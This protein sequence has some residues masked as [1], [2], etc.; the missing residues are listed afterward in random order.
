M[1]KPLELSMGTQTDSHFEVPT[2]RN[3]Y[4]YIYNSLGFISPNKSVRL[5]ILFPL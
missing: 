3:N 2:A 1:T 5:I 4:I